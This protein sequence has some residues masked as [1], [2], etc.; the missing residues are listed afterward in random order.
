MQTCSYCYKDKKVSDFS[1]ASSICRECHRRINLKKY[2]GISLTEYNKMYDLQ[3]GKCFICDKQVERYKLAV[4]HN[5]T[6]KRVRKLLCHN[7]NVLIGH[8]KE[9]TEILTKAISY[10]MEHQF[11]N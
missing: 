7:C 9:D 10:L 6:T 4:D 8:A 11:D 2:Y 5:H 1:K 3:E